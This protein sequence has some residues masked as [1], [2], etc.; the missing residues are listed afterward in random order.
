MQSEQDVLD[1]LTCCLCPNDADMFDDMD[2]PMCEQCMRQEVE[3]YPIPNHKRTV[4][5][6][7]TIESKP[8]SRFDK[9]KSKALSLWQ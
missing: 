4:F 2:N 6:Q 7:P 9:I 3:Q 1:T 8:P 5:K